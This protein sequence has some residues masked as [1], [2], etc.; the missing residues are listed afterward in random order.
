MHVRVIIF[1]MFA[2]GT[3]VPYFPLLFGTREYEWMY[4]MLRV[5]NPIVMLELVSRSN[6]GSY[7]DAIATS[8]I[9]V[10]GV[11]SGL[12]LFLNVRPMWLGFIEVMR[13]P[14]SPSSISTSRTATQEAV[15]SEQPT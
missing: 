13:S 9:I 6:Y 12:G 7:N 14:V 11:A 5:M 8:E 4:R 3:I 15:P 10:L 1:I 2:M